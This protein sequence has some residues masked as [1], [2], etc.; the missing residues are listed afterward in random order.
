MLKRVD[1]AV[2]DAF[3]DAMMG[4]MTTGTLSLGLAENGVDYALDRHNEDLM[5]PEM[6]AAIEQAKEAIIAGELEVESY[7]ESQE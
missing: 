4:E 1:V 7:Y 6:V 5:T 3:T 2:F